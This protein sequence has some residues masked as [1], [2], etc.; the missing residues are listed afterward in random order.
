MDMFNRSIRG[1]LNPFQSALG[2]DSLGHWIIKDDEEARSFIQWLTTQSGYSINEIIEEL[3]YQLS[4]SH[5]D[6]NIFSKNDG[7]IKSISGKSSGGEAVFK[8]ALDNLEIMC[9]KCGR[10][11]KYGAT[12]LV[13]DK[14]LDE[15]KEERISRKVKRIHKHYKLLSYRFCPDCYAEYEVNQKKKANRKTLIILGAILI[16][17]ISIWLF[18]ETALFIIIALAAILILPFAIYG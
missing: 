3:E 13:T 10:L 18:G 16:A 5:N 11:V 7:L 17:G 15:V 8:D 12:N 14:F 2:F 6:N 9:H 1:F 4:K